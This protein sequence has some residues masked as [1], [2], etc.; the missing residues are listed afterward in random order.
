MVFSELPYKINKC[1]IFRFKM[2]LKVIIFHYVDISWQI[3]Q[4]IFSLNLIRHT[5]LNTFL[6]QFNVSL[7]WHFQIALSYKDTNDKS[8]KFEIYQPRLERCL[9]TFG[10]QTST[11]HTVQMN[12]KIKMS[13]TIIANDFL[14]SWRH[15]RCVVLD[16][17]DLIRNNTKI[18]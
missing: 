1:W 15:Y 18:K 11:I 12:G 5:N 13:Y 4:I 9:L 14:L 17:T 3:K 7:H 8:A 2:F 10:I 16:D 6:L